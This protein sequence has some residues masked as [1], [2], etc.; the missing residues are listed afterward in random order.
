[1]EFLLFCFKMCCEEI[2]KKEFKMKCINKFGE[3]IIRE[4]FNMMIVELVEGRLEVLNKR[5]SDIKDMLCDYY[6]KDEDECVEYG[7]CCCF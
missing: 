2:D 6:D 5:W 4:F 1:M 3:E 7:G